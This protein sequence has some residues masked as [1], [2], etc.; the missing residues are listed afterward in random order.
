MS[1]FRFVANSWSEAWAHRRV[2]VPV[3]LAMRLLALAVIAPLMGLFVN[4]AVGLSSQSALTDQD[5]AMFILTPAGLAATL[6]VVSILLLVEVLSFTVMTATLR[7]GELRLFPAL[8]DA[9]Y[10]VLGRGRSLLL[11]ALLF[12]IKVLLLAAPFLLAGLAVAAWQLGSYDINYYLAYHPPEFLLTIGVC[13]VLAGVMVLV[14]LGRASG[15][16]LALHMVIFEKAGP[17]SAFRDSMDD[18]HGRRMRLSLQVVIWFAIRGIMAAGLAAL[19]GLVLNLMPLEPGQGLKLAL[20]LSLCVIAIWALAGLV[21]AAVALGALACLLDRVYGKP[22]E[23]VQTPAGAST[24]IRRGLAVGGAAMAGL[25]VVGFGTGAA[26]LDRIS[27]TDQVEIIGHRGAAGS[28]PENTMASIEQAIVDGAD[29]VEIDVQET[30]EGEI[31]VIH[32]SDF[33]KLAKVPT[34][35]WDATAADLAEIDIGSWFDPSFADERTPMLRD[36]LATAQG[37][38]K[39][40]IELK[41]YGHDV[42][43]EN[44]VIAL[45]E[46]AGMADQVAT[47]S[48]KYPAV[49]KML[50]LRPDWRAGTLAATAV[51]DLAGLDGDFIAVNAGIANVALVDAVNA[52]GKDLYVW[53]VNDPLQMSRMISM[54]VNGLIT[55]EPALAHRVL[56][57]RAGLSTPERLVLWISQSLGMELNAKTYRDDSP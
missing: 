22:G 53:T 24:S 35:I 26:L 23:K 5:I 12:L 16:A 33:M 56:D 29:W 31:A 39:V 8:R 17:R 2:F 48:L 40:L 9:A 57:V 27:S 47:M 1:N 43:L 36:V 11:F 32:D 6:G 7:S 52:S 51:G 54:G 19:A 46:E 3:Y 14:I 37:R 25:A 4:L 49:Q 55:D 20:L 34:K 44:R 21:L 18:M 38:A 15:W 42:D 41:Y 45:V 10:L 28:H 30:A 50:T 13:A